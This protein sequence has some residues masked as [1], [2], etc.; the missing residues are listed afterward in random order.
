MDYTVLA[1]EINTDPLTM[2]YA[3][4]ITSGADLAI[5]DLLNS[6]TGNG[7]AQINIILMP[8][9]DFLISLLPGIA[10]LSGMSAALQTKW[11]RLI[12]VA[13][14]NDNIAVSSLAVGAILDIAVQDGLLTSQQ[15][16]VIGKRTGSR[17]EVI[18]G[19]GTVVN[20]SDVA[21]ALRPQN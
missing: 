10:A 4:F 9:G 2:G 7:T 8:R 21:K 12:T 14:A 15:R 11:D 5:A 3:P 16:N 17:A 13:C 1:N 18:F 20:H 6:A 19:A